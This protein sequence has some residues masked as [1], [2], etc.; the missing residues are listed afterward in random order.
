METIKLFYNDPYMTDFTATVLSCEENKGGYAVVLDRTAFFPEG[1]GQY[2][3][4][5]TLGDAQVRDVRI[6]QGHIMH[7]TDRPLAVGETERG[8]IDAELRLAKMQCHTGEHII[9]GL[10]HRHYGYE[11][12]GFHL[13]NGEMTMDLDGELTPEQ[14]E[15]LERMTA[16]A[17]RTQTTLCILAPRDERARNR[18]CRRLVS[19]HNGTSVDNRGYLLLF[20]VEGLPKQHFSL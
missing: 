9:S 20:N 4:I 6:K 13:G 3:D 11:N 15:Q 14:I 7:L 2:A 12:V 5:G 16:E 10:A 17:H 8:E 1:G 18:Q 19:E